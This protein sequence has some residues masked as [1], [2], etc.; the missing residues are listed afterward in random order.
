LDSL[1]SPLPRWRNSRETRAA[2]RLRAFQGIQPLAHRPFEEIAMPY[3]FLYSRLPQIAEAE[4]RTITILNH[5]GVLERFGVPPGTYAFREMF[6]D[7]PGCDCRRVM[8]WVAS[9]KRDEAVIA[10]GWESRAFYGRW[11]GDGDPESIRQLQG[12]ALNL[13][14]DQTELAD[15]LLRLTSEVLL[16]DR[17]YIERVKRHYQQFRS[18]LRVELRAH[19]GSAGPARNALCPCGSGKKSKR[20]CSSGAALRVLPSLD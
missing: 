19:S 3:A 2:D 13:G 6:C 11:I 7:E 4:T 15:G 14:S 17:E 20:C 16:K 5:G 9:E 18:A 1:E 12:P 8:W 10:W